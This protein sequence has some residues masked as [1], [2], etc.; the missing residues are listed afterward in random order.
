MSVQTAPPMPTTPESNARQLIADA[1]SGT[2]GR[3][4]I[5][6]AIA[7][8]VCLV[9]GVVGFLF[10]RHLDDTLGA[11]RAHAAQL[12]RIQAIR[13]SV[14]KADAAATNAFLVGG[15]EPAAVRQSYTD[16]INTAATSIAA[17]SSAEPSDSATLQGVNKELATYTGLIEAARANNRQGFPIGAAY[18]REAS[19]SV[20]NSVLPPLEQLANRERDRVNSAST[21]AENTY[22]AIFWLLVAAVIVL[23]AIQ[24]WLFRRTR[25][26]LNT[27]LAAATLIVLVFGGIALGILAST[28]DKSNKA[29]DGPYAET[30]AL[31]TARINGFDAKSAE[32]LTLIA[33]GSGQA[34]E[35]RFQNVVADAHN[36]LAGLTN[37]QTG[38]GEITTAN[39][40]NAYIAQHK[41]VR[42]DDDGG[43]W[44]AAVAL[45]TGN[46]KANTAFATFDTASGDALNARAQQLSD[47]LA[48]ARGL[49][50]TLSWALL[51]AGVLAAFL[52][53]R[54]IA[55]RLREYR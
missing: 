14:V 38:P 36:A 19:S 8:A 29:K 47:D 9:F 28:M 43:N 31:A 52:A 17:A 2:P 49:L 18:L 51:L 3:M 40:L 7:V 5:Y 42:K 1:F 12:V 35:E 39:D 33:R 54:G 15:L 48:H 53:R 16:G 27:P 21:S 30:V 4:R 26:V 22:T 41:V 20:E 10:V 24:I 23:V 46:G 55:R 6:G 37:A 11:E 44:D 25:R 34:Y 50:L 45:A 32:S 13:T